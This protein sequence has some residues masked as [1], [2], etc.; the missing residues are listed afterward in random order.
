MIL[1]DSVSK[2]YGTNISAV[3]DVSFKI[4]D[5]EFVFL[6]GVSGAG[7]TTLLRLINREILPTSGS[8]FVDDWE[9]SKL[10]KSKLPFLRRK[11]GFVYQ[12][13]KLLQDR[14]VGENIAVA[15]EIL[16]KDNREI[17]RRIREVLEVV[18]L[19]DKINYFPRQLSLGEQQR[20][21][22]GR[23]IAGETKVLLADEPTGNLDPKTS[24][25]ILKI[26]NKIHKEGTTV[27]MASHNVDIVNSLKKRVIALSKGQI[28]RDEK[29]SR[30]S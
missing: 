25:E 15:L 18:H 17:N 1:F 19:E 30:Y 4:E 13:F 29:R 8:V 12:D 26:I 23:A 14:T 7:K 27:L 24:W 22:I 2:S 9:V 28:T 5:G 6:V 20:I 16:N 21:A 3:K 10:P 11:V